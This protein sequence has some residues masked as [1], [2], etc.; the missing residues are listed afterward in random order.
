MLLRRSWGSSRCFLIPTLLHCYSC[1]SLRCLSEWHL[2]L[3]LVLSTVVCLPDTDL[4]KPFCYIF[5]PAL[6]V[7]GSACCVWINRHVFSAPRRFTVERLS[8]PERNK[9]GSNLQFTIQANESVSYS[10]LWST[11]SYLYLPAEKKK[12]ILVSNPSPEEQLSNHN[13]TTVGTA[14]LWGHML[15]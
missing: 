10:A 14:G 9:S 8:S 11:N 2:P 3:L 4:I 15:K 13:L 5:T 7:C 12:I 1:S 6:K